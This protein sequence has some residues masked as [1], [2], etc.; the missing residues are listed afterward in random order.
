MLTVSRKR[1][2]GNT[3]FLRES[4]RAVPCGIPTSGLLCGHPSYALDSEYLVDPID[5]SSG[6]EK[7]S[8]MPTHLCYGPSAFRK[9]N[10]QKCPTSRYARQQQLAVQDRYARNMGAAWESH[11]VNLQFDKQQSRIAERQE[12]YAAEKPKPRGP[13]RFG[14]QQPQRDDNRQQ[15]NNATHQESE[16][17]SDTEEQP[18]VQADSGNGNGDANNGGQDTTGDQGDVDEAKK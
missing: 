7:D 4:R 12:K 16:S 13:P 8:A 11:K 9:G 10:G 6:S 5:I 18:P 15:N 1:T 3:R 17:E 2:W 14:G